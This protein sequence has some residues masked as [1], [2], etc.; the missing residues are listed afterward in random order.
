MRTDHLVGS[1]LEHLPAPTAAAV[2]RV[3]TRVK[4]PALT[5][6]E[7]QAAFPVSGLISIRGAHRYGVEIASMARESGITSIIGPDFI[8]IAQTSA[9]YISVPLPKFL[10]LAADHPALSDIKLQCD[11][12]LHQQ[13]MHLAV[14][15]AVHRGNERVARLLLRAGNAV[16]ANESRF[17][18]LTQ[19]SI[20]EA[21]AL[22]RT[23]VTIHAERLR[24]IG[25]IQ[26]R[27]GKIWILN[28]DLLRTH[29]CGCAPA[30]AG[31]HWPQT[32]CPHQREV[33]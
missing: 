23:T 16:G 33:A 14:C 2:A 7:E 26:Y 21:L 29:A 28:R 11:G 5:T 32:N 20:G 27:R 3:A 22:R 25:A 19:D 10:R 8:A 1:R 30:L 24:E 6:I 17:L 13:A 12:F 18:D 31:A 9:T 15:N 4:V